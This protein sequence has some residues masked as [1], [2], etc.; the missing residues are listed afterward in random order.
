MMRFGWM[1]AAILSLFVFATTAQARV[2][3]RVNLS[4]QTMHVSNEA[5]ESYVWP[6]SSGRMGYSTPRGV[7]KPQRLA[8]MHYSRKYQMS[9]M[10]YSIFFRGGYAIHGT[11]AVGKLGQVA[12]HGC[13]RL[14]PA[15]AAKLFAMVQRE[16][17][18]IAID[19][20]SPFKTQYAKTGA[21]KKQFAKAKA[22]KMKLAKIKAKR[23]YDLPMAYAPGHHGGS[24][25]T[26]VTQPNAWR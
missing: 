11:S 21:K 26:W 9:P 17:A 15:N 8:R 2:N 16:G 13:I 12:S 24:L 18:T 7:Y 3:V 14:A 6:V 20:T 10:P 25:K 19:G 4:S 22:G 1:V 23:S 5:G